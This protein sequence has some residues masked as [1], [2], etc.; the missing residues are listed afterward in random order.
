MLT[1]HSF[2]N[3]TAVQLEEL[4]AERRAD[5]PPSNKENLRKM[6]LDQLRQEYVSGF[7]MPDL[8]NANTLKLFRIWDQDWSSLNVI[9][10]VRVMQD[11]TVSESKFPPKGLY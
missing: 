5:R 4:Q 10:F 3:N 9:T 11:G 2:I 6:E 8:R 7:W 1:D